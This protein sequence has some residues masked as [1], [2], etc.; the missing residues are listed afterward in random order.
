[1]GGCREPAQRT[2][3]RVG[4][5]GRRAGQSNSCFILLLQKAVVKR[6]IRMHRMAVRGPH[7]M[8]GSCWNLSRVVFSKRAEW[9]YRGRSQGTRQGT[10][11]RVA[12]RYPWI[13]SKAPWLV[14]WEGREM[15]RWSAR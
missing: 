9:R 11:G 10:R 1:M 15:K 7:P 3:S 6:V 14:P 8:P 13:A 4:A 12:P 5:S 2:E